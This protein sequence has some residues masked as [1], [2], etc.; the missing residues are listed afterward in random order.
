MTGTLTFLIV[1]SQ[2]ARKTVEEEDSGED[3]MVRIATHSTFTVS[4]IN[5]E[6]NPIT[7]KNK[8]VKDFC[9]LKC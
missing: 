1:P 2:E 3:I 9:F 6:K 5:P 4:L 7:I 8:F